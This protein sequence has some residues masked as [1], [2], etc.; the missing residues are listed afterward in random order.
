MGI[1]FIAI[2]QAVHMILHFCCTTYPK[3]IDNMH[4]MSHSMF[5]KKRLGRYMQVQLC[6]Y[7]IVFHGWE[8]IT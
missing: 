1:A 2:P 3:S 6:L 8:V 5:R 4:G 7:N